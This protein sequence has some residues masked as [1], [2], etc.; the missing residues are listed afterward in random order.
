MRVFLGSSQEAVTRGT[1]GDIAVWI[2]RFGHEPVPWNKPGL[3]LAGSYVFPRLLEISKEIEAALFI[4]AEDDQV[5]YRGD[6]TTQPR[7]NVLIEYG[8]FA[9]ALGMNRAVLCREGKPRTPSDLT[10][11]ISIDV[12]NN[13]RSQAEVA[14]RAWL[15]SLEGQKDIARSGLERVGPLGNRRF[16]DAA[17]NGVVSD[18]QRKHQVLGS[19][20]L[21]PRELLESL[22]VLFDRKTFRQ[23]SLL[24]CTLQNWPDR[25]HIA[26]QTLEI[27]RAY[28]RNIQYFGSPEQYKL[29][30]R[31]LEAVDRYCMTM[32]TYLFEQV[33]DENE[34]KKYVGTP[35]FSS[36]LPKKR[37]FT[38]EGG[39]LQ[40][41]DS[42]WDDSRKEACNVMD[43]L[44]PPLA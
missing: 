38:E 8:L 14:M 28:Q 11:I 21:R 20:L 15:K 4:F 40:D 39:V 13:K 27:L 7:D 33:I 44:L 26:Y 2:E 23:E 18:L 12:T 16:F 42:S 3:F 31:L 25:L 30:R 10:G 36:R 5:W 37:E 29:Y 35:E 34:V 6:F 41:M 24:S 17:I 19:D 1:M 9:G 43:T 32:A 22:D